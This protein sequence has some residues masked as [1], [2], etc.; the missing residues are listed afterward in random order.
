MF[1]VAVALFPSLLGWGFSV[2]FRRRQPRS[3]R[4]WGNSF[5]SK[6]G[7]FPGEGGKKL[8]RLRWFFPPCPP[9]A[10]DCCEKPW[11]SVTWGSEL[12]SKQLRERGQET[13]QTPK[14][15]APFPRGGKRLFSVPVALSPALLGWGLSPGNSNLKDRLNSYHVTSHKTKKDSS[16]IGHTESY[17][18]L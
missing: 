8:R 11:V 14:F 18:C 15:P 7:T 13:S 17:F 16:A 12:T 1:S 10:L 4:G 9:N 2:C 3:L 5:P 6:A